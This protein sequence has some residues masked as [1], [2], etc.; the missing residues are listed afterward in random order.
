MV[1]TL[2]LVSNSPTRLATPE[3]ERGS[4]FTSFV[5]T[6]S[7]S[8]TK[9]KTRSRALSEI[10]PTSGDSQTESDTKLLY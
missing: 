1:M 4:I 9:D 6:T 10:D 3:N 7:L 8:Y 5:F 2:H